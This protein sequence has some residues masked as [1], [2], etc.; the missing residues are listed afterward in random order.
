MVSGIRKYVASLIILKAH[1]GLAEYGDQT[2]ARTIITYWRITAVA[3]LVLLQ[4]AD[5]TISEIT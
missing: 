4:V 3:I 2:V 5:I 1:M